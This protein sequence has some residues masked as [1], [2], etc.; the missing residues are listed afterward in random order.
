MQ[1]ANF[2]FSYTA[3]LLL[4]SLAYSSVKWQPGL[5]NCCYCNKYANAYCSSHCLEAHSQ[6]SFV[7]TFCGLC[8]IFH[9][10]HNNKRMLQSVWFNSRGD[11]KC[12]RVELVKRDPSDLKLL[13]CT[14]CKS[15]TYRHTCLVFLASG[16]K[17]AR[18]HRVSRV[19]ILIVA[20]SYKNAND[21]MKK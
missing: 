13:Q 19:T 16:Q 21:E 6:F 7:V 11:E 14:Y 17:N 1:V 10:C 4:F 3:P 9:F 8:V 5:I 15:Q 18:I 2:T 20:R 12:L